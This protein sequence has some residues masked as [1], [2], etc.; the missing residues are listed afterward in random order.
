MTNHKYRAE[1]KSA[2]AYTKWKITSPFSCR[3]QTDIGR[4]L[5]RTQTIA[6]IYTIDKPVLPLDR[7]KDPSAPPVSRVW[8]LRSMGDFRG[9]THTST[10]H[11][12]R[13][14][15]FSVTELWTW[16]RGFPVTERS[17][18]PGQTGEED[19]INFDFSGDQIRVLSLN[20]PATRTHCYMAFSIV[21]YLSVILTI[22]RPIYSEND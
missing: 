12:S 8:W 16:G 22:V 14:T 18:S 21:Q 13:S 10:R 9:A 6:T 7:R 4:G 19:L 15:S 17:Q 3:L 5:L 11:N 2:L 1:A 20:I